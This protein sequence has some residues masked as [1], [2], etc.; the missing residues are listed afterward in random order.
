MSVSHVRFHAPQADDALL[1]EQ[2]QSATPEQ[3]DAAA[4][5]QQQPQQQPERAMRKRLSTRTSSGMEYTSE[6]EDEEAM[7]LAPE[8]GAAAAH[9]HQRSP[10]LDAPFWSVITYRWL[11]PFMAVGAKK[12]LTE[13]DMHELMPADRARLLMEGIQQAQ[14]EIDAEDA[15]AAAA[16]APEKAA[17]RNSAWRLVRILF[18]QLGGS[19][20]RVNLLLLLYSA[21]KILQPLMLS[22]LV[23]FVASDEPGWHGYLYAVAMG[24]G[25]LLQA[26]CHHQYFWLS[27]RT[28]IDVRIALNALIFGKALTLRTA[29]MSRT[30]TGQ[31]VNLVSNDSGRADD[32]LIYIPSER[33]SGGSVRVSGCSSDHRSKWTDCC[34]LAAFAGAGTCGTVPWSWRWCWVCCICRWAWRRSWAW[35]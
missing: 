32:A 14:R 10:Y 6:Q 17:R 24:L 4:E 8:V 20:L 11:S 31:V 34:L 15:A 35:A 1:D 26:C 3:D 13:D 30:T 28:G 21:C 23:Q 18:R 16:A 25:A 12:V 33:H 2:F 5:Q 22:Q 7:Q 9:A 29:A 19:Y 27:S